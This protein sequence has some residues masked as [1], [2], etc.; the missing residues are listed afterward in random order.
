MCEQ[1]ASNE[2]P[3]VLV[4]KEVKYQCFL[5]EKIALSGAMLYIIFK[6]EELCGN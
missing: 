3:H 1:G 5:N 2:Y 4:K 6:R